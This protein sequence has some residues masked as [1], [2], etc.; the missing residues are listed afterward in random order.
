MVKKMNVLACIGTLT[1]GITLSSSA[2]AVNYNYYQQAQSDLYLLIGYPSTTLYDTLTGGSGGPPK[3]G[4]LGMVNYINQS[5]ITAAKASG[6]ASCE[7]APS[8]GTLTASFDPGTGNTSTLTTGT[9]MTATF[10]TP[11]HTIPTG[12]K[13]AGTKFS[14]RANITLTDAAF[15]AIKV[16]VEFMCGSDQA[17]TEF[18][19]AAT[20]QSWS[21]DAT[22]IINMYTDN[23]D[24]T[25]QKTE[26][27]MTVSKSG[28]TYDSQL[29][30]LLINSSTGDF[31]I[32]G[33]NTYFRGSDTTNG[34]YQ[35]Y[36]LGIT[37]N[38]KTSTETT[39]LNTKTFSTTSASV[40]GTTADYTS[41]AATGFAFS[42]TMSYAS[43]ILGGCLNFTTMADPTST[44][45]CTG[46]SLTTPS[47]PVVSDSGSFTYSWVAGTMP[48]LVS[49]SF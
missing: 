11:T 8:S 28:T 41:E 21:G 43:S 34:V 40:T 20:N 1:A 14:K 25:A 10:A 27:M 19:I 36:R 15:G 24:S 3:E 22:R 17:F 23:S 47:A 29:I 49:M 31:T 18:S 42:G 4:L 35:G 13:N 9:A 39:Y 16:G 2:Y 46:Y 12:H 33:V 48:G 45:G 44:A 37:G 38:T 32:N 7:A 30:R 5:F 6:I 26:F